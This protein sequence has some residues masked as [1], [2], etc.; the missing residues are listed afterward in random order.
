MT[1]GRKI[2]GGYAIVLALLA[3]VA[4]VG[5]HSLAV[6]ERAYA[7]FL[8]T[9]TEAIL[10]AMHLMLEA[11]DQVAHYRGMLLHPHQH[12]QLVSELRESHRQFAA[13]LD[14]LRRL[15]PPEAG[16][17][18]LD[19]IAGI[20]K[21]FSEMQEQG[22]RLVEQGRRDEAVSQNDHVMRL[23]VALRE[24]C[25][26]YVE[27]RRARLTEGRTEATRMVDR[28]FLLLSSISAI[29]VLLGLAFGALLTRTI[30]HQLGGSVARLSGS[31]TEILATTA[32]VSSQNAKHISDSAQ[33]DPQVSRDAPAEAAGRSL[34]ELRQRLTRRPAQGRPE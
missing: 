15:P 29:A 8:D 7:E 5:F 18:L 13:R 11:R 23:G 25:G 16:D 22:I 17:R 12:A 14:G 20:A 31:A 27:L 4:G 30:T 6:T 21:E 9:D 34:R 3:T 28:T 19:E 24:R 32:Q 1:I 2:I 26:R 10:G 33:K